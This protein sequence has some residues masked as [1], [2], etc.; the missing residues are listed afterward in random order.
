MELTQ[1]D[2][3]KDGY[4]ITGEFKSAKNR[5]GDPTSFMEYKLQD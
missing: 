3:R 1:Y 2:L 4:N 5:Y